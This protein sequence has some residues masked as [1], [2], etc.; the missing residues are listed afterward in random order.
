MAR[1][2]RG[3][4]SRL[5][6]DPGDPCAWWMRAAYHPAGGPHHSWW[7]QADDRGLQAIAAPHTGPGHHCHTLREHGQDR[8][9]RPADLVGLKFDEH[10]VMV[11][12]TDEKTKKLR[13]VRLVA[14]EYLQ[15]HLEVSHA[16]GRA[17]GLVF[18]S[19]R[20]HSM[21]YPDFESMYKRSPNEPESRS[22]STST[23]EKVPDYRAD[24]EAPARVNN[25]AIKWLGERHHPGVGDLRGAMLPGYRW[26]GPGHVWGS[27]RPRRQDLTSWH[28]SSA[29][30]A[31]WSTLL[32]PGSVSAV[33]PRSRTW[34]GRL[35][36]TRKSQQNLTPCMR[37]NWFV[38][39]QWWG[40][41]PER[42]G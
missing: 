23:C 11:T 3:L 10:G 22:G 14:A 28:Q 15:R 42:W 21:T 5:G 4:H 29:R 2:A 16:R 34:P 33:G 12:I 24:Q 25:Q 39:T 35:S 20:G 1:A 26:R 27:E 40:A 19:E 8:G 32:H 41:W 31:W 17:E 13:Y 38:R 37:N 7:G 18:L 36:R 30:S 9:D 6:E